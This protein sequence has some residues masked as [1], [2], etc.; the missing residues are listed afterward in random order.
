MQ[1]S[2]KKQSI[3]RKTQKNT[4]LTFFLNRIKIEYRGGNM[5]L[6][7]V[8]FDDATNKRIQHSKRWCR[9]AFRDC[10][11]NPWCVFHLVGVVGRNLFVP[12]KTKETSM[13]CN[14]CDT[15]CSSV[16]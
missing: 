7:S 13:G 3:C 12:R 5:Y 4:I 11:S 15:G 9:V 2:L 14:W 10:V 8:Y 16:A 6:I 1:T